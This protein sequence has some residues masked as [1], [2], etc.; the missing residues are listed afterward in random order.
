MPANSTMWSYLWDLVDD[1]IDDLFARGNG[2]SRQRSVMARTGRL[3]DVVADL[4]R[5]T[6]GEDG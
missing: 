4:V 6:C 1:G 2:A 5:A 3:T